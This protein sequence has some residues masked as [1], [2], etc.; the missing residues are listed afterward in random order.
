MLHLLLEL[1]QRASVDAGDGFGERRFGVGI[2]RGEVGVPHHLGPVGVLAEA[3]PPVFL[4]SG[5]AVQASI[6]GL[7]SITSLVED[8]HPREGIDEHR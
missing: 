4:R 1:G 8:E 3:R 7:G 2:N 5:D 6:T